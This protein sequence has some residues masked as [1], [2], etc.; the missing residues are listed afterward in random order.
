MLSLADALF[1]LVVASYIGGLRTVGL[2]VGTALVGVVLVR[3]QGRG[4]PVR[5]QRRLAQGEPPTDELT[6][7]AMILFGI[8]C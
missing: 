8:A 6:D 2:V 4:T 5:I 7:G 1:L 3:N